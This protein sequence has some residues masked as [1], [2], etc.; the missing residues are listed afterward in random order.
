MFKIIQEFNLQEL[1]DMIN[2]DIDQWFDELVETFRVKGKD[3]TERA[4]SK[5]EAGMKVY[6]NITWNLVS[7]IGYC[8]LFQGRIIESYF[9]ALKGG[10]SGETKGRELAERVGLY[11]GDDDGVILV[12]V[13]G[14][15]YARFLQSKDWDVID[16]SILVFES[17]LASMYS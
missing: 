17:E 6:N 1:E 8:L 14:E 10:T 3:F 7:S 9:P 4:R 2:G 12:L 13:A 11:E 15:K 5:A 16:N